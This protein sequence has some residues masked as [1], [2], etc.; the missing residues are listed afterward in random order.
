[1]R[2][3]HI[4]YK[5]A[6]R[7]LCVGFEGQTGHRRAQ[8]RA[9]NADIHHIRIGAPLPMHRARA[10]RLSKFQHPHPRG[11]NVLHDIAPLDDKRTGS[12][13]QSGMQDRAIFRDI[14]LFAGKHSGSFF[15][16]IDLVEE[17]QKHLTGFM[18]NICLG[19]VEKQP[20]GLHRE[21]GGSLIIK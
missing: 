16:K 6:P 13:A 21:L 5:M 17:R 3:I 4:A 11:Q 18:I 15:G 1:M 12:A 20:I 2:A 7:A 8:I 19:I 10:H 9:T 14:H